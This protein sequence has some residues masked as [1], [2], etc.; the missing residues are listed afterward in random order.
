VSDVIAKPFCWML[1]TEFELEPILE[2]YIQTYLDGSS[3]PYQIVFKDRDE[4]TNDFL[5]A[6]LFFSNPKHSQKGLT[7]EHFLEAYCKLHNQVAAI[8]DAFFPPPF[9]SV[10]K[11]T[12]GNPNNRKKP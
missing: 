10:W 2:Q 5:Y 1:R 7:F 4:K 3:W 9:S 6:V 12:L 11:H 8:N